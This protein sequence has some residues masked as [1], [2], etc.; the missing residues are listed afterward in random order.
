MSNLRGI[1]QRM[2]RFSETAED[3]I[4][5]ISTQLDAERISELE[6]MVAE[7]RS[8]LI[9]VE[10]EVPALTEQ[11]RDLLA[12]QFDKLIQTTS[13]QSL[14][15]TYDATFF[16]EH[17]QDTREVLARQLIRHYSNVAPSRQPPAIWTK[18]VAAKGVM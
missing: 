12:E 9:S 17:D 18:L 2:A 13:A 11:G 7:L 16:R 4:A 5:S 1:L 15:V 10:K 3:L 8:D 6:A 14:V